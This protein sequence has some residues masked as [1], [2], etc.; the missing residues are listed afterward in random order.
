MQSVFTPIEQGTWPSAQA[1]YYYTQ[2][3]PTTYTINVSVDVTTARKALKE[4]GL[5]FFPAYL[6]LVTKAVG[7]QRELRMAKQNDALG[8]W[9]CLTPVYP[10]FHEDDKTISLLWTEYDDDF[11]V[12]YS[13]YTEDAAQHG[14]SHGILSSKGI[15]PENAY[16]VSCVPWFTFNSF[17]LHN[18]GIKDHF[19]PSLEAGG[20]TESSGIILMP[21]SVTAHHATTDGYHL[22]LFFEEL[23]GLMNEPAEWL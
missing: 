8:Y 1:F 18:H 7:K 15:P 9:N 23:Q 22:K 19:V 3:A 6:Y 14:D 2:M 17:S 11:K 12:F 16:I 5:K 4:K 13:R 20:F 10:T 21:L